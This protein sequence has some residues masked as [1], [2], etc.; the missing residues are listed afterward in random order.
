MQQLVN[1]ASMQISKVAI[2]HPIYFII[3][4]TL[5][6]AQQQSCEPAPKDNSKG[7]EKLNNNDNNNNGNEEDDNITQ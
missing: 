3:S 4:N 5:W 6:I 1:P 7:K 2:I